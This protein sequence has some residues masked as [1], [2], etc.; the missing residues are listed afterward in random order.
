MREDADIKRD[1]EAELRWDPQVDEAHIGV[2]VVDGAVTLTGRV[3]TYASRRAA[4]RVA[5]RVLGVRAVAEDIKVELV[6]EHVEDD[7]ELA[8]RIA[9][10]LAWD[11]GIPNDSIRAE[12][13]NGLVTLSGEV[14]WRFQRETIEEKVEHLRGVRGVANA[15]TVAKAASIPE[16]KREIV[17]ALHRA[18]DMEARQ[19]TVEMKGSTVVLSGPVRAWYERELARKAAWSAP[20]VTSVEDRLHVQ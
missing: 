13:R 1:V 3:K 8:R 12:V 5:L 7:S 18:A 20:G 11:A 4:E 9:H 6:A 16:V 10:M 2:S 17:R 19:I 15:I 14:Q